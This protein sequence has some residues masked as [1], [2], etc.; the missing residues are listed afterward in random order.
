[1][2]NYVLYFEIVLALEYLESAEIPKDQVS[3]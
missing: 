1:M 2:C 3:Y